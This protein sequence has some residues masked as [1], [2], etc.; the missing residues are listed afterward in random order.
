MAG[1]V[2]EERELVADVPDLASGGWT[3]ATV[4]WRRDPL[5]GRSAR[6]VQGSKLLS[7]NRPDL[8]PLT[9]T[10]PFCPFCVEH[11][12][13]A[14][15]PFPA[16]LT[17]V[18]RFRRGR[19]VVVPNVLAYA[20]HTAVGIYD[21]ERHFLDLDELTPGLVADALGAMVDHA[22]AVRRF[23]PSAVWSSINA[24]FLP[25]SGSSLVH[26]HLQSAHDACGLSVQRE[27]VE[28]SAAWDGR[29]SF[30]AELVAAERHGPRWIGVDGPVS[31]LAAFAPTGFYEVWGIVDGIGDVVD[32]GDEH[33]MA[34][35]TGLSRV[36]GAYLDA[37]L[38]SFNYAVL[39][40]GPAAL[41]RR[42]RLLVKVVARSNPE[43]MYRSDVTYFERL[44]GEAM[45]DVA[46]E[47]VAELVRA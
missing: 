5:T 11:L 39:G 30:W 33:L 25:P 47:R 42:Y 16:A 26:P 46:P 32:L 21:A 18:G 12:E 22:R 35:G 45:I 3:R 7:V 34:L 27:L 40:G 9:A 24:N 20:S 14:T 6:I 23:D 43:P 38:A 44:G 19:A 13:R 2:F 36:F 29:D 31:W 17:D 15:R 1:I 28:R 37:N 41:E 8:G 10:P 4:R